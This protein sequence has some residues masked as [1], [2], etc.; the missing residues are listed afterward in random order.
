MSISR[1]VGVARQC[2]HLQRRAARCGTRL[3]A[4]GPRYCFQLR[5]CSHRDAPGNGCQGYASLPLRWQY[6]ARLGA[7]HCGQRVRAEAPREPG[8]ATIELRP[9]PRHPLQSRS[10]HL[11]QRAGA[12]PRRAV[13]CRLPVPDA[14]RRLGRRRRTGARHR[15][16][17]P[18]RSCSATPSRSSWRTSRCRCRAFACA[19]GSTRARCGTSSWCSRAPRTSARSRAT[20][21]MA[22]RRADW[23]SA[24]RIPTG[25]EFP[26]FT[27]F[28]IERPSANASAI[29]VHALLDSPVGR[30]RVSLFGHA[31]R[32]NGDGRRRHAVPA[33]RARQHRHRAADFDVPVR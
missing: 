1:R 33:R 9:V 3:L 10:G 5:G 31:G 32:G 30:G 20:R 6:R 22:C 18:T 23:R 15:A 27:H 19:R 13:P 25:E 29:V 2:A 24:L 21:S 8:T 11:A 14:G 17:G 7:P 26:A 12:V 4:A 16:G 28:W